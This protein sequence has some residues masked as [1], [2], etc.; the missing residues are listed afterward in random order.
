MHLYQ[1]EIRVGL[2]NYANFTKAIFFVC[3]EKLTDCTKSN[4]GICKPE[5]IADNYW[6]NFI[7]FNNQV[8]IFYLYTL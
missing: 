1:T 5:D 8:Q 2:I 7:L 3:S 6:I 4:L